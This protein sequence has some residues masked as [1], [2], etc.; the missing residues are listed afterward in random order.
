MLKIAEICQI[1]G[2]LNRAEDQILILLTHAV[3]GKKIT[4]LYSLPFCIYPRQLMS[5]ASRIF[6]FTILAASTVVCTDPLTRFFLCITPTRFW[7]L[8]K[9]CPGAPSFWIHFAV[10]IIQI[11]RLTLVNGLTIVL[12]LCILGVC[13]GSGFASVTPETPSAH[14]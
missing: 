13:W 1:L 10:K 2:T 12:M 8:L 11:R 6:C 3:K 14:G 5:M 4:T 9:F 7:L